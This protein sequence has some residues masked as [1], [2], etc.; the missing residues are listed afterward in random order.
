MAMFRSTLLLLPLLLL[1]VN[2]CASHGSQAHNHRV[3]KFGGHHFPI[4]Q[5]LKASLS[6][7]AGPW[8]GFK[9]LLDAKL[10]EV[11]A[12]M[13]NLKM[14][15]LQFGYIS[16][17]DAPPAGSSF[18]EEFDSITQKAIQNYQRS[19]GLPVTGNLDLATLTQMI[20]P[21]CGREDVIN[22][23]L[24]MLQNG[25]DSVPGT[26]HLGVQHW[27]SFPG[28]RRWT[29]KNLTYAINLSTI[30]S[31]VSV[32]DTQNTIDKA[33]ATWQAAI[34]LNFTRIMNIETADIRISFDALDHGD[35]NAFDG[36]LGVLAHAFAPTDGRLHFDMEEYW[37]IDVKTATSSGSFD[38]LSVAIHEIGHI[39]G[40]EHSNF[41]DAIMYP[42][43][44]PLVAKQSLH[45][46][47][48]AGVQALYEADPKYTG[49]PVTEGLGSQ[50][51]AVASWDRMRTS[52]GMVLVVCM[53]MSLLVG[54]SLLPVIW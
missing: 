34:T 25:F 36:P 26:Q 46:D 41:Q 47:D 51:G 8:D 7:N 23:T 6:D 12:G 37:T 32:V 21:R 38:L 28:G 45:A 1:L 9:L 18:S 5:G 22:G 4:G 33:F 35:G 43:I 44:S 3:V 2:S 16:S 11:R 30:S 14:Y 39:L 10:G 52:E 40:L 20:I 49:S 27:S 29:K 15:L 50:S 24:L 48:V 31:G 42:S 17:A 19:F 13:A 53:F 54:R